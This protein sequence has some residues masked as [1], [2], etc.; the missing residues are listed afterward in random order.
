MNDVEWLLYRRVD[1]DDE[2]GRHLVANSS[3]EK[4]RLVLAERPLLALPSL[5]NI[6]YHATCHGCLAFV[7]GP[8]AT[9][10]RR[11]RGIIVNQVA[12][13]NHAKAAAAVSLLSD[14]EDDYTVI[15]CRHGCG[16]VYC[17]TECERDT[18]SGHHY[19]LCTG[20]CENDDAP[21]VRFKRFAVET[22]EILLL[23]AEWWVAQHTTALLVLRD[24]ASDDPTAIRHHQASSY[25]DF[26][27]NPWWDILTA[28]QA[29]QDN[30]QQ[31]EENNEDWS[32]DRAADNSHRGSHHN[33]QAML[34]QMCTDAA[35]LLNQVFAEAS[36]VSTSSASSS[37]ITTLRIPAITA[38]DIA[39]RIGACEQNAMGIRQRSPLCRD[40]FDLLL[41][42]DD[43]NDD[44][45]I[46]GN[47]NNIINSSSLD[48][49][50]ALVQCLDEA[51]F[52]GGGAG[53]DNEAT[54]DDDEDLHNE[55]P[56]DVEPDTHKE[57]H[58]DE[59]Q[60]SNSSSSNTSE[61]KAKKAV[62]VPG[63]EENDDGDE[64]GGET[65][66][67]TPAE[68]AQFI[69]SLRIDEDGSVRDL[70][71]PTTNRSSSSS[72]NEHDDDDVGATV[73]DDLDLVFPPLDGT[74]MYSTTCKMNHSCDPNIMVVYRRLPGW[75]R[76]FPLT[77]FSVTT[78]DV[79]AG[80]ELTISYIDA[81]ESYEERTKA[82]G[83]YGF[84]CRCHRCI[85]ERGE[86]NNSNNNNNG[87]DGGL[88]P[89]VADDLVNNMDAAKLDVI[90]ADEL[91]GSDG[92]VEDH[93]AHD[94]EED[95]A[96]DDGLAKLQQ[97]LLRLDTT[98]N[99]SKFGL[100]P[101]KVFSSAS[102]FVM[103]TAKRIAS[104][105]HAT[106]S[107]RGGLLD[108]CVS[109]L[110]QRDYCL[111][112]IVG[113]NLEAL[114]MSSV[115]AA[116]GFV[117]Q[118]PERALYWCAALTAALGLSYDY[119]FI[120]AQ[121]L[122]DKA[123]TLGLCSSTEGYSPFF[124]YVE[125]FSWQ[126]SQGP[127]T[128]IAVSDCFGSGTEA[129][130][131]MAESEIQT[132]SPIPEIS[133]AI[134]SSDFD[135]LLA[136]AEPAVFRQMASHWPAIKKW[137]NQRYL[138]DIGG[139]RVVPIELGSMVGGSMK[140]T[141]MTWRQFIEGYLVPSNEHGCWSLQDSCRRVKQVA[142]MAQHPLM[143]QLTALRD[144]VSMFDLFSAPL[145]ETMMWVGTGGTRTPLHF[146]SYDNLFVQVVGYKYVRLYAPEQTPRLYVLSGDDSAA[147]SKQG[148][149]SALD[150][151]REDFEKYTM[152]AD[153]VFADVLLG[154]GDC[155]FI[156][157]HSWHYVRSLTSSISV[158][159]WI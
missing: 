91:F 80:E 17:S 82:L 121:V 147:F 76:H 75:G 19:C 62:S 126:M 9:L 16:H 81:N 65:W 31:N 131:Q 45:N 52:I 34:E 135:V 134:S 51:G 85:K 68:I 38:L 3:L 114:A 145:K 55:R 144:D 63:E 79:A 25:T 102:A 2:R 43:D 49:C 48:V 100:I 132:D 33:L 37:T 30:E 13:N 32:E 93:T 111:A 88:G 10:Q 139:H 54:N 140:E 115:A 7:G 74:A 50:Q 83:S 122:C 44:D 28:E 129:Y 105:V 104:D 73:G 14:A 84:T 87:A 136:S 58:H 152:A 125:R 60:G 154:P 47:D 128:C 15:P 118:L 20:K 148:N 42:S 21:L 103:V 106:D 36:S 158:N 146:D 6:R 8:H 113:C 138:C 56:N 5:D 77:A 137:Q 18:W 70:A 90:N 141:F 40:V 64:N 89:Q 127:C 1:S 12:S 57:S 92:E 143:G 101:Q 66:N 86:N 59:Q 157:A 142:Y 23:V 35:D 130:R 39:K 29:K 117:H 151:E 53:E 97:I 150:C 95:K 22:N 123:Y 110:Q 112:K 108:Q 98:A 94:V 159:F 133:R 24:A 116:G 153:A 78:R 4:G 124:R 41:C 26:T 156:P 149:M 46:D 119:N 11:W 96:A 107:R 71:V 155:L 27:M 99:H 67:Y 109:A 61:L 120:E 72:D 69:A